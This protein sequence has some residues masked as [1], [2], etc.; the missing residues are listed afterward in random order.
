MIVRRLDTSI[1]GKRPIDGEDRL[2]H[3]GPAWPWL[4]SLAMTPLRDV[5]KARCKERMRAVGDSFLEVKIQL[6]VE[7]R[8]ELEVACRKLVREESVA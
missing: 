8:E 1:L 7:A 3:F 4:Q 2:H 6:F 5:L